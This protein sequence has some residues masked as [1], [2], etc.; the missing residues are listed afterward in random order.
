MY[1]ALIDAITSALIDSELHAKSGASVPWGPGKKV[2][3]KTYN[4]IGDKVGS[5]R[6]V[7]PIDRN[8][9]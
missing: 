4:N 5:T 9:S 3:L 7:G 6:T 8:Y 2:K 1:V